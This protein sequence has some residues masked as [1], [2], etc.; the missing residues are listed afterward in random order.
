MTIEQFAAALNTHVQAYHRAA[1]NVGT[2][3]TITI[4]EGKRYARIVYSDGCSRSA[5]G[6]IDMQTG[7]ILK[8][9]GWKGPAKH[10]RGNI[11]SEKPLSCCGPYGV[12]YLR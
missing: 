10:A 4:E 11:N 8:S 3:P 12:A 7:D 1:Q 9:A 5:Y 6:F 2:P